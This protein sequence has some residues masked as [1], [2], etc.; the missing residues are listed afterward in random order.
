MMTAATMPV[1]AA[2]MPVRAAAVPVR[3]AAVPVRAAAVPAT[4]VPAAAMPTTAMIVAAMPA[5]A[6]ITATAAVKSRRHDHASAPPVRHA[7]A[8]DVSVISGSAAAGSERNSR[9]RV[10]RRRGRHR[11]G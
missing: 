6:I 1:R 3:A 5:A 9:I 2:P 8:V 7:S 10:V 11:R 4:P